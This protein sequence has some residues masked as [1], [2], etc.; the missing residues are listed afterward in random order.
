M[1]LNITVE[2]SDR[3]VLEG[4]LRSPSIRSGLAQRARIV[5]LAADGVGTNEIV[6]AGRGVQADGHLVEEALCGGRGG[7]LEGS[8]E[9][10]R[11]PQLL[12][13]FGPEEG[14]RTY[15]PAAPRDQSRAVEEG[16]RSL[17]SLRNWVM[18]PSR[19]SMTA[20]YSIKQLVEFDK[21]LVDLSERL[22]RWLCV[23]REDARR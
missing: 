22:H 10:C 8:P 16:D 2:L 3:A 21:R 4:W 13:V 11:R 20:E 9:G 18:H 1:A 14:H 5:S 17:D 23:E 15:S 12:S 7:R 19:A 6:E